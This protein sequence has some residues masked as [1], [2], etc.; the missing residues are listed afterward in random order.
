MCLYWFQNTRQPAYLLM[1]AQQQFKHQMKMWRKLAVEGCI[2][3]L[4][5]NCKTETYKG[6]NYYG[7]CIQ[8]HNPATGELE[9]AHDP[10]S[11]MLFGF[12]CSGITYWMTAKTNRD[13]IVKYV[14]KDID[15]NRFH[16]K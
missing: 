13:R 15:E 14:M 16:D 5:C 11:L 1:E 6:R 7:I 2:N 8:A 12:M 3:I 9:E 10:L 4:S